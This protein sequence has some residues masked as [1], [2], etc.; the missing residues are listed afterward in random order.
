MSRLIGAGI[1]PLAMIRTVCGR[2]PQTYNRTI[3]VPSAWETLPGLENYRGTA[4][5]RTDVER[6]DEKALRLVFGGVSHTATVF[7]DGKKSG[8]HCDA[9]YAVQR[10]RAGRKVQNS[11]CRH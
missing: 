10:S 7:V 4:W 1:S 6:S 3:Q 2:L 5:L 8:N 11:G 9:L